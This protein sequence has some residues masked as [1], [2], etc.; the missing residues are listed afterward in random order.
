MFVKSGVPPIPRW[1]QIATF[2]KGMSN[3]RERLKNQLSE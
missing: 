1:N 3:L 2:F